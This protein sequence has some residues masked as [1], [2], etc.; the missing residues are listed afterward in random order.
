M[1]KALSFGRR[2]RHERDRLGLSQA[3]FAEIGGV[4][5]TTQHLY[6]SDVRVPDVT[7]LERVR[8]A[9]AD[10]GYLF[11]NESSSVSH[12]EAV[13]LTHETL[14]EIYK[15]V[16]QI[17]RDEEGALLPLG[18]RLRLFQLLCASVTERGSNPAGLD[19]L[20]SELARFTGT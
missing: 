1:V 11:M 8:T 19:S 13:Q 4:G 20:R 9:G 17:G 18:S 14:S 16:D 7:Y 15:A 5:R 6:E 2:L 12:S 3:A 10:L